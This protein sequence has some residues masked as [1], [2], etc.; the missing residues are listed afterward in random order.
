MPINRLLPNHGV[1]LSTRLAQ[2]RARSVVA[3]ISLKVISAGLSNRHSCLQD[4]HLRAISSG[5]AAL[6]KAESLPQLAR[7]PYQ[8]QNDTKGAND[9]K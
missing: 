1:W 5:I 6:C 2:F 8:A 3:V 7:I 4:I 9:A